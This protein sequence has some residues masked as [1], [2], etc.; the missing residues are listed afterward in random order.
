MSTVSSSTSDLLTSS[1]STTSTS[2]STTSSSS[3]SSTSTS[4]IDWDGLIEEAVA[5]KLT[6]ATTIETKISD[7]ETTIAAYEELQTLLQNFAEAADV[8][9]AAS[10]T[11]STSDDAFSSR[12]AYL[13]AN[14]DVEASDSVGATVESGSA[15]GS[16]DLTITQLAQ[17]HKLGSTTQSSSTTELEYDGVISLGTD[18]GTSAEITIT[19]DMTLDEVAEAINAETDTSGVKASVLKVSDDEYMLV[20][21]SENTGETITASS[22]SG[23]DVLNELGVLDDN[24]DFADELQEAQQAIFT[25]DGIEM[26]RSSNTVSDAID[27]VTLLLYQETP[28]DTS[29]TI[30]VGTNL[31]TVKEAITDLVDAYNEFR[32][33]A[34]ANQQA[35][36]EDDEEDTS[37][38]FGDGTLRNIS[39]S[40][41]NALNTTIDS[42]S[43]SLLGLSFDETNMLELDEDVLDDILLD[44]PDAVE[45]LL[46][47]S[48][49]SSSSKVMLLSRG[50]EVL[51]DLNIEI[52]VDSDGDLASATVDGVD[53]S[54]GFTVDGSRI[55]GVEGTIY[56]G[57]T[58]VFTGSSDISVELNF[59]T[60]IAELL[61]NA[62]YDV[63]EDSDDG[64]LQT[65]MDDLEEVND[66][67][68]SEVATIEDRAE[69]YRTNLTNRYAEY[70]AA[71]ETAESM[72]DY[73]TTLIDTWNA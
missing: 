3:S 30:E 68:E 23:D 58:F 72:L 65:L 62:T 46:T 9:R 26:T 51:T 39:S 33:F 28:D 15:T 12:A 31:T 7:N 71:I 48:M 44:D 43:M 10:G 63:S 19:S 59:S 64:T 22:V 37:V 14:G 16:Y 55:I 18:A 36:D 50:E 11:S 53:A 32:E 40:V 69:T 66:N 1:Y 61:Y 5:A 42:E 21:S 8:L 27:G 49:E 35:P 52:T 70:Q 4:D 67:L 24:G 47:F 34:Y 25:I 6:K 20:L 45:S 60:G 13:T 56:E 54:E 73:L 29:I 2:T 38:L 17:A 41:T 57:Y